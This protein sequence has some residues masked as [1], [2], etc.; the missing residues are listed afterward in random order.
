M[1]GEPS[2]ERGVAPGFCRA[3]FKGAGEGGVEEVRAVEDC[4][5]ALGQEDWGWMGSGEGGR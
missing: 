3:V 1:S 2:V 5:G 4:L